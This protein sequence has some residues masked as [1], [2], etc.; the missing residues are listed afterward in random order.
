V[1]PNSAIAQ[2]T[3]TNYSATSRASRVNIPI[4]LESD[5]PVPQAL[6]LLVEGAQAA[7]ASGHILPEPAPKAVVDK[8]ESF[9]ISYKVQVY[10]DMSAASRD[11]AT[12]VVVDSVMR[13]LAKRAIRTAWPKQFSVVSGEPWSSDAKPQPAARPVGAVTESSQTAAE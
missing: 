3:V 9:G 13:H 2:A 4:V 7:I 11:V 1:V 10:H 8:I 5:V 12:T 6:G